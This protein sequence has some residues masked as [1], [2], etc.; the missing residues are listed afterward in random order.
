MG[1]PGPFGSSGR[2][3]AWADNPVVGNNPNPHN[4]NILS[5]E[6]VN[7]FTIMEVEYPDCK[8]YEGKKILVF[9]KHLNVL[10]LLNQKMIDPHFSDNPSIIHPIARFIPTEYGLKMARV[11][12]GAMV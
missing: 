8:N 2:S 11:F 5:I 7:N 3:S 12:C 10:K 6:V 9:E 4:Y 1:M